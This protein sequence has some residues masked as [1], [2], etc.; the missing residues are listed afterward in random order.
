MHPRDVAE[1]VQASVAAVS[2]RLACRPELGVAA[3]DLEDDTD[4]FVR[5][6]STVWSL[7]MAQARHV[8]DRGRVMVTNTVGVDLSARQ[9]VERVLHFGL[10][11]YDSQPPTANLLDAGRRPLPF[12]SWPKEQGVAGVVPEHPEF[13]RPFFCRPGLREYHRHFQHEDDPWDRHREGLALH[14][15]VI[16]LLD[17]FRM[18]WALR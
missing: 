8:D 17:D 7:G 5:F 12:P 2:E 1:H 14:E 16:G 4:L 9:R 15:T 6:T 3:V 13:R 11:D 10:D 18:R